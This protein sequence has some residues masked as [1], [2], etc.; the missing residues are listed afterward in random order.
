MISARGLKEE[1]CEIRSPNL[2]NKERKVL[3]LRVNRN[4]IEVYKYVRKELCQCSAILIEQAWSI[5]DLLRDFRKSVSCEKN[6]VV[7]SGQDS[8]LG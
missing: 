1:N 3:F 6:R 5:N 4:G 7:P 2:N 8:P